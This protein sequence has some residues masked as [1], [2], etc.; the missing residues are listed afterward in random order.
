MLDLKK[1]YF[2]AVGCHSLNTIVRWASMHAIKVDEEISL[3]TCG[4]AY[5]LDVQY[6][7]ELAIEVKKGTEY[8]LDGE[9]VIGRISYDLLSTETCVVVHSDF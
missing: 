2:V 6:N 5:E 7:D 9:Q 3:A 4:C 8:L 1:R